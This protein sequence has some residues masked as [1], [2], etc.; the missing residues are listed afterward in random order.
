ALKVYMMLGGVAPQTNDDLIVSWMEADWETLFPGPQNASA[1]NQLEAHLRAMLTLD[2]G[3][4]PSFDLNGI[5]IDSAQRTLT[6][7]TI[8]EQAYAYLKTLT[9]DVPIED[10]NVA[11]RAGPEANVV[12]ET[13]DG[14]DFNALTIP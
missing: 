2:K 7:L 8:A 10:F 5:L 11:Q 1:R 14:S 12:F 13:V 4:R 3:Q 6:R 9:P